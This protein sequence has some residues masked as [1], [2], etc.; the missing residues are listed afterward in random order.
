MCLERFSGSRRDPVFSVR[1]RYQIRQSESIETQT[2]PNQIL[3][4]ASVQQL[5]FME[6]LPG[7]LSSRLPRR[8]AGRA[9]GAV[10]LPAARWGRNDTAKIA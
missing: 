8:A 5:L 6:L 3:K 7:P 10:D 1:A 2:C 9:V 4:N